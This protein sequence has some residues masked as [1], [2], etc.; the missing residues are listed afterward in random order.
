MHCR[1][2]LVTDVLETCTILVAYNQQVRFVSQKSQQVFS[3]FVGIVCLQI[4]RMFLITK[5][6]VLKK[7]RRPVYAIVLS[8]RPNRAILKEL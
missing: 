6:F 7:V 5:R 4:T 2:Y 8:S 1:I 3:S